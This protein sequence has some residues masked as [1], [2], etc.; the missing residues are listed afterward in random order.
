VVTVYHEYL[1]ARHAGPYA[2]PVKSIPH[3]HTFSP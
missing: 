3:S 2:E 1:Q